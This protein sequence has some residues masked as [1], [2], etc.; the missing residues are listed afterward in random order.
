MNSNEPKRVSRA[1]IIAAS[2]GAGAVLAGGATMAISSY[3]TEPGSV[4]SDPIFTP[5]EDTTTPQY[6]IPTSS[7]TINTEAPD[8]G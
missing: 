8:V 6:P 1:K 4:M 3:N 5:T 2:I 7:T